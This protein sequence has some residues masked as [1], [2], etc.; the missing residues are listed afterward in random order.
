MDQFEKKNVAKKLKKK[1]KTLCESTMNHL[2]R[3]NVSL[4][5]FNFFFIVKAKA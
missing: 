5:P 1:K 3:H 2:K 4:S